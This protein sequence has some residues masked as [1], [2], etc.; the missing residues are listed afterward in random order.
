MPEESPSPDAKEESA[1]SKAAEKPVKKSARK[2]AAKKADD[3]GARGDESRDAAKD[4]ARSVESKAPPAKQV[5]QRGRGRGRGRQDK[6]QADEPRVDFDRK[7]VAKRAWKIFLGEVGE[8]G[9]S[10]IADNDARELA[11]RSIKIAEIYTREE[12]VEA[13]KHSGKASS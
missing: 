13:G 4:E 2:P 7:I 11:R 5:K 9:L 10:L 3:P 8:E 1:P 6:P 12:A